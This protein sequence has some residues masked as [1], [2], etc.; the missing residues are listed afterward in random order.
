MSFI[1]YADEIKD[2]DIV[3]LYLGVD[4][5]L[6]LKVKAGKTHQ[7]KYG[8]V[9]HSDLIG[10][11]YG[12]KIRCVG[13]KGWLYVLHPT[14]E[15]WTITLP[16]RTQ[17]VYSNDIS[18]ITMQLD[19]KPGSVVCESGT[20]SGSVSHA[21]IRTIAPTGHL[22]TFDYHNQRV[23]TVR[24]EFKDHGLSDLV[25][26]TCRDVSK[27]GFGL[28]HIADAVFLDLPSPYDVIDAAKQALKVPG[29]RICSFSPCIEQV[30]RTCE[31]LRNAGFV[32]I[33]T[34]ESIVRNYDV[35]TIQLPLADMGPETTPTEVTDLTEDSSDVTE[36]SRDTEKKRKLD[37]SE[38]DTKN[39]GTLNKMQKSESGS[40]F[41][42]R[43]FSSG[44]TAKCGILPRETS[45]HTGFLTFATLYTL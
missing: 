28:D 4:D 34:L 45:G 6:A 37:E 8:A 41:Q 33:T 21:I 20:G 43:K 36:P 35:K 42:K 19:L 25:T 17:I 24:Q 26:V 13:G 44:F 15:L 16:H 3:I 38:G 32:E 39:D 9:R 22:Y 31:Q 12:S 11:K 18:M 23:E 10:K 27:D 2:G 30:Q 1:E 29:G 5:T 40:D 7:T 14:P